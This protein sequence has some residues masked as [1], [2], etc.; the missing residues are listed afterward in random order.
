MKSRSRRIGIVYRVIFVLASAVLACL[1]TYA[2]APPQDID[3]TLAIETEIARDDIVPF[4]R[5]DVA[6]RGGIVTLTG[7]V[8]SLAAK[9]RAENLAALV[10]GVRSV[11]NRIE[12]SPSERSME[13]VLTDVRAAL[14]V[15]RAADSYEIEAQIEQHGTVTLTGRVESWAERFLA[16]RTVET[17][18]GVTAI[19]NQLDVDESRAY[20]NEGEIRDDIVARLNWDVRVDDSL[21]NVIAREGGRV[22]LSGTVGSLA[23]KNV[24]EQLAWVEGVSELDAD[25][26]EIERWA[27]DEDLR[28]GKY[29]ARSEAEVRAALLRALAYDP[30]VLATKID[31]RVHDNAVWLRGLVADVRARRAAEETAYNT[32]GVERVVNNLRVR[33][34]IRTDAALETLVTQSL[35][36]YRG[37]IDDGVKVAVD[38]GRVRLSGDV[39]TL[40]DFWRVD[41]TVSAMDG[42]E[43]FDNRLTIAGDAPLLTV[44][45]F[46]SYPSAVKR[47]VDPRIGAVKTDREIYR[48][49]QSELFWSPFIDESDIDFDIEDGVLTLKGVADSPLERRAARENAWDAGAIAVRDEMEIRKPSG[50]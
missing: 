12:V 1:P 26:L 8:A 13:E 38:D 25:N 33:P 21:I 46:A 3:V 42:V 34:E 37:L 15:S 40:L 36:Q 7:T 41:Q 39:D 45:L 28:R 31:V 18:A 20:R 6:T 17:V 27:R 16:E 10:K 32:V 24:A 22:I 14:D 23:E 47:V 35:G 2:Q 48:D 43:E 19:E 44:D 4:N 30:R 29:V 9:S 49:F 5:I 50:G 11:I